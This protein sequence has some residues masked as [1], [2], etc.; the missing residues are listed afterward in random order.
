M[1]AMVSAL[2]VS[3]GRRRMP[4]T[5][6]VTSL[7]LVWIAPVRPGVVLGDSMAPS[8]R[9]GQVFLMWRVRDRSQIEQGE[10]VV[11]QVR[12]E[13]YLKRVRATAGQSVWGVE[14][15]DLEG[16][17]DVIVSHPEAERVRLVA[18]ERP[19]MGRVVNITVPPGHVFVVGDAER[20]S[21]DSRHFGPVPLKAVQGRVVAPHLFSLWSP[22]RAGTSVVI[23]GAP[24]A[25]IGG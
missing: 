9:N 11:F 15:D 18:R 13:R 2:R 4:L 23:A 12:G 20:N 3:C 1:R 5:L 19:G 24:E 14:S 6:A 16:V 21:Y 17:P 25:K 8:F 7:F 10:V 22:R